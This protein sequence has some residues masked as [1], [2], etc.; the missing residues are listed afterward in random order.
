VTISALKGAG[1]HSVWDAVRLSRGA[2][3]GGRSAPV[4]EPSTLV[5]ALEAIGAGLLSL[6]GMRRRRRAA[7]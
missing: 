2:T 5:L 1:P 4:P 3:D 6:A 7:A